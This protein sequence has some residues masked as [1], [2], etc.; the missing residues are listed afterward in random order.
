MRNA[1][2][3]DGTAN[4]LPTEIVSVPHTS[5]GMRSI[6]M[7]AAR[8]RSSVTTKLAAPTVVDTPSKIIPNA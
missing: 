4:R 1:K 8:M 7:P 2:L 3:T 5:T 6:D